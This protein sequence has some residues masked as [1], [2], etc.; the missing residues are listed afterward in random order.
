MQFTERELT[1]AVEAAARLTM[2]ASSPPW[3]RKDADTAWED[4]PALKKYQY[5]AAAGEVVL[6][7]LTAL[8]ERP[9]VG[10]RPEFTEQELGE[11]AE[12]VVRHQVE[13]R[14]EGAWEKLS[15]RK[16]AALVASTVAFVRAALA[17]MPVRR[18]PDDPE[19]FVVPDHL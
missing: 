2:A 14:R 8:P 19:N 12:G 5:R 9:V 6:P 15:D 10:A 7:A 1:A 11:A 18:D 16:R 17:A 3:R 4:A 13:A